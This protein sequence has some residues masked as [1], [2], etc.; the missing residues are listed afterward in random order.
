MNAWYSGATV[1]QVANVCGDVG[2]I[3]SAIGDANPGTPPNWGNAFAQLPADVTTALGNPPPVHRDAVIWKRVL[4]AYS[5]A[6]NGSGAT[7]GA[8]NQAI[9]RGFE[10]AALMAQHARWRW[11]PSTGTLLVCFNTNP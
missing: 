10:S 5:N 6:E 4:N 7:I 11:T 9:M 8:T 2:Q 3:Q 1:V